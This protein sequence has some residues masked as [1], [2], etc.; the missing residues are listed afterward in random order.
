[1]TEAYDLIDRIFHPGSVAFVG[2]T[3]SDPTHWTRV[4]WNSALEFQFQGPLYAVNPHGGEIDGYKVFRSIDEIPGTVDYAVSTVSA[5]IASKIV[6][7]CA[8]K[9]VKAIHFCT[10]G[11]AET[12]DEDVADLQK[13]LVKAGRETGVRIIGPNCMGIYCPESRLAFDTAFPKESGSVGFISQSGGNAI[14]T[15]READWK[16]VRFSKVVSFGNACDLNE[17][18]FLEYMIEDP[19]TKIIALYLEGVQDGK[20]FRRLLEKAASVKPVVLVKG[21]CGEAGARATSSHTGSLAGNND[22]WDALCRQLNVIKAKNMEEMVDVMATL[23]FMPDF[24]GQNML[25]IG[26]GG[27]ASVMIT[28]E[29]ERRGFKLPPVTEKIRKELLGFSQAAGNMLRNPIDYSQSMH[30]PES[31]SKAIRLL[32]E[33]DQIDLCVWFFRPSQMPDNFLDMVSQ[34][35]SMITVAFEASAKPVAQ[36]IE[37]GVTPVRQSLAFEMAQKVA[38]S[39]KP[40][41]YSFPAAAQAL[42]LVADYNKRKISRL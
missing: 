30:N 12:G 2:V 33:W 17:S 28:D 18:D 27:G 13:E 21:G 38:A 19:K 14:Y 36:I 32:T 40:V 34:A 6:R 20:R 42:R 31:I 9:G 23:Q 7:D 22:I 1:M 5:R 29:F 3:T 10:A 11:F 35:A 25:L 15:I 8:R 39:G 4:F 24:K 16:G 41:Y 37:H 26:P